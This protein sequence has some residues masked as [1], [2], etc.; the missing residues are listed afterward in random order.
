MNNAFSAEFAHLRA[1]TSSEPPDWIEIRFV[2]QMLEPYAST[3][4]LNEALEDLITAP[5]RACLILATNRLEVAFRRANRDVP[6]AKLGE[7]DD[8]SSPV[9]DPE[10]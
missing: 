2:F 4:E 8:S 9:V 5:N 3:P 6:G 10:A 7:T 1:A